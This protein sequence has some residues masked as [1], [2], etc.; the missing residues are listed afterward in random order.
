LLPA[1]VRHAAVLTLLSL[2]S[3]CQAPAPSSP[4][5]E[6]EISLAETGSTGHF[7]SCYELDSSA[8]ELRLLVYKAGPLARVG[9]NHVIVSHELAGALARSEPFHASQAQ[10]TLPVSSLVI[11][12]AAQRGEEGVDFTSDVSDEARAGT[13]AN[14]LGAEV[15]NAAAYPDV[16]VDLLAL[17]GPN[18]SADATI[19]IRLKDAVRDKNVRISVLEEAAGLRAISSFSIRQT[20]FG[21]TPFSVLGG[22]LRVADEVTIRVNLMFT[23]STVDSSSCISNVEQQTEGG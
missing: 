23:A 13:L 21:M 3:G 1:A 14:M 9:H 15:L 2:L 12:P 19:R 4:G 18:W 17:S 8:S 5:P 20:D 7:L 22:G 6:A 11:D 16:Q 10:V